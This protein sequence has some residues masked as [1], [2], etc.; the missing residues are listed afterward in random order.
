MNIFTSCQRSRFFIYVNITGLAIGLAASI[1][2]IMF[3]VNE[4]S[5]DRHFADADRIVRLLTVY[6]KNGKLNYSPI[7]LRKAYSELPNSV[8]EVEAAVQIYNAY[9]VEVTCEQKRFQKVKSLLTDPE[10]FKIFK[11]KFIEGTPETALAAPNSAVFTRRQAEIMFGSTEKAINQTVSL[12]GSDFTV[13]GIVEE[14]P[15]NTHFGF[16]M[17]APTKAIPWLNEVG[18]LEF[19]S[20][21]LIRKE[22]PVETARANI[23]KAYLPI[24]ALWG[25]RIGDKE[26]SGVTEMLSDAYLNSKAS[27]SLGATSSMNYI[28]ILTILAMFILLLAVSNFISLFVAQGEMRM[29]EIGIRKANGARIGDIVRLFFTEISTIVGIAFIIGFVAAILC[30]PYF[31]ELINRNIDLMQLFTPSFIIAA[32]ALF[33]VTAGLSAFYPAIYLSRFSPLEILCKRIR[34]SRRRL[35]ASVVVFQSVVSIVLLSIIY[36]LY[37]QTSYLEKLPAGYNTENVM[38]FWFN[39]IGD[40]YHAVRQEL[41]NLPEVKA[42]SGSHHIFGY[43]Y[44]GQSIAPWDDEEKVMTVN[45]YRLMTGMPELMELELLEGRFWRDD[46]P[47]STG[48]IIINATAAKILSGDN[49]PLETCYHYP[50]HRGPVKVIGIVKDFYYDNPAL[51]VAPIVLSRIRW[52]NCI[53]IRFI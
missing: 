49:P 13:S 22:S 20:Y 10:F 15:K 46:D 3:V 27:F 7:C 37:S 44:S 32:V 39:N 23:E 26:A 24:V 38:S 16:D 30:V 41:L 29:K 25:E 6:S 51:T 9:D 11:M 40:N 12:L 17:L 33:V 18:G 21:Y 48:M 28:R 1:M 35:T 36:M 53:N 2:L 8:P 43:G 47:D 42:V 50:N 19:H 14:L 4:L 34:F 31:G 52:A 45:E 5:Y